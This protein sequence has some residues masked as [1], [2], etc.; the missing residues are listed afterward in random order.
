G[1]SANIVFADADLP[2]A[3]AGAVT[4]FTYNAGQI[5]IAGSRLLVEAAIAD[6]FTERLV[7]AVARIRPGTDMGPIITSD[8]F[9]RVQD[10]F[11]VATAEG[12]VAAIG[13]ARV[14]GAGQFVSPTVYT[15]V[16]PRMRIAREEVFGPVACVLPFTSEEEAVATANDSD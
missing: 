13:G 14:D 5:C 11:D 12:A 8:Q 1:K 16:D 3:V 6:E 10:F 2:R 9:R 15:G 7:D 4:A